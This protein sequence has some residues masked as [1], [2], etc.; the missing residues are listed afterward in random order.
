MQE[1]K[2]PSVLT[3]RNISGFIRS[4]TASTKYVFHMPTRTFAVGHEDDS[5]KNIAMAA[6]NIT[7]IPAE[8]K[9]DYA[10]GM[11]L[12]PY[13]GTMGVAEGS[14]FFGKTDVLPVENCLGNILRQDG[15]RVEVDNSSGTTRL[16]FPPASELPCLLGA[17]NQPLFFNASAKIRSRYLL[18]FINRQVYW[19]SAI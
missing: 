3:P 8:R 10:A 12:M 1:F 6:L 2:L 15:Y 7:D 9:S 13:S 17:G 18:C 4:G 14:G 11:L 16:D 5:H 19:A